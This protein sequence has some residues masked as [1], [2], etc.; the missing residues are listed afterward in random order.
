LSQYAQ[1]LRRQPSR[2]G[3]FG[4]LDFKPGFSQ[5]DG[6]KRYCASATCRQ[7]GVA[8]DGVRRLEVVIP[9]GIF[10]AELTRIVLPFV[11]EL[12]NVLNGLGVLL[13]FYRRSD[14]N[15]TARLRESHCGY[16]H[17]NHCGS[18]SADFISFS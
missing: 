10:S 1:R 8:A 15:L 7:S 18:D 12:L 2:F 9:S 13:P 6:T 5:R 16:Q 3:G 17:Q 11:S 14:V 4:L